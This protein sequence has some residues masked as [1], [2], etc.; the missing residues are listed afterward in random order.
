VPEVTR[1]EE[2]T[3]EAVRELGN[4]AVPL[5]LPMGSVE[6]HGPH[7]PLGTDTLIADGL[8]TRVAREREIVIAPPYWY[9]AWSRPKSGGGRSFIGSIGIT[10][11]AMVAG[12][13]GL[14]AELFRQGLNRLVL[15]N[16]HFENAHAA[17]EALDELIGPGGRYSPE[18][19]AQVK[20]ILVNWWDLLTDEDV[21]RI[22]GDD[23]PGWPAEHAGVLETA[24]MEALYPAL[25]RTDRKAKGGAER[26]TLYDVFPPPA[27]TLWPNG[28]GSTSLPASPEL[29]E[30][31][32]SLVVERVV[33]ALDREFGD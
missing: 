3:F 1:L 24:V 12:L 23:F 6:Q 2:L 5:V 16:A 29:G 32:A 20:A 21:E 13:K 31:T 30:Q 26:V 14:F 10:S 8:A 22:F 19:G 18:N 9:S 25:V 33:E 4:R 28:I 27:D 15:L 17:F 7:L 11:S